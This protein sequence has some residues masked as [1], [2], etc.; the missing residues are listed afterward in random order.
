LWIWA[1]ILIILKLLFFFIKN[2]SFFINNV[3]HI[4]I[5]F[6]EN[7][8]GLNSYTKHKNKEESKLPRK[9]I[10][11]KFYYFN[12]SIDEALIWVYSIFF[13]LNYFFFST[14]RID[15]RTRSSKYNY[16]NYFTFNF[17]YYLYGLLSIWYSIVYWT[18]SLFLAVVSIYYMMYTHII[19]FNKVVFLWFCIIMFFYWL[20][21]GF[22]FFFK[23]YQFSKFT[24]AIQRFWR[25]AYIIFWVLESFLFLFFFFYVLN[26]SQE[27]SYMY[28]FVQL[29]KTHLFS[30]KFFLIKIIPN[31]FL[32]IITNVLLLSL[33]SSSYTKYLLFL[34]LN[35]WILTYVVW[36]EFYQFFFVITWYGDLSW[37]FDFSE[38]LWNLEAAFKRTRLVNNY[39]TI[40]VMAKFWHLVFIYFFWLYSILRTSES[41]RVRYPLLSANLQNFLI[42]YIM[43]FLLMYPWLK[44]VIRRYYSSIYYWFFAQ[45]RKFFIRGFL[46]DVRLYFYGL[47]N[48]IN[49]LIFNKSFYKNYRFFYWNESSIF[50][51]YNQFKKWYIRD[52]FI[53]LINFY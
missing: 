40:C 19:S 21:S 52:V 34:G 42:L 9:K 10:N 47:E 38:R 50:S 37:I 12:K 32:L 46:Y 25:R 53:K 23:K 18:I 14:P 6:F 7:S 17:N 3:K 28:D 8:L 39:I 49:E 13:S 15:Y 36:L 2:I 27:P 5:V 1:T 44:F 16:F 41:S 29:N 24:S 48:S 51:G 20:V 30:W 4:L 33:K 31:A 11:F 26:A 43:N 35:T 45:P 22:V